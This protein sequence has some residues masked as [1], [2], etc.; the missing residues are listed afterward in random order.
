MTGMS[1]SSS[2]N[3]IEGGKNSSISGSI[4]PEHGQ[5]GSTTVEVQAECGRETNILKAFGE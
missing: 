5:R 3:G 2:V 4:V 1:L